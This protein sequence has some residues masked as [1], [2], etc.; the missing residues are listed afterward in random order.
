[1]NHFAIIVA[2]DEGTLDIVAQQSDFEIIPGTARYFDTLTTAADPIFG[3]GNVIN[4]DG[5]GWVALGRYV[6]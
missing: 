5:G 3:N 4:I 6:G 2:Q 1:M